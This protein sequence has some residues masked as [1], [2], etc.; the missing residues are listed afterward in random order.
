MSAMT[1]RLYLAWLARNGLQGPRRSRG[2]G[3][4][5]HVASRPITCPAH[6][7]PALVGGPDYHVSDDDGI[8]ALSVPSKTGNLPRGAL[9]WP[10]PGLVSAP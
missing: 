6:G 9:R 7:S 3:G 2:D 1:E 8:P 5:P 10:R 4:H